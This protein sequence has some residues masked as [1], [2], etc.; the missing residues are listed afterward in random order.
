MMNRV[1]DYQFYKEE[2]LKDY[3]I[4]KTITLKTNKQ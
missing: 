2:R 1:N 4:I 3:L